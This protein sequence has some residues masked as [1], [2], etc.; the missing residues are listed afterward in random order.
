M[1]QFSSPFDAVAGSKLTGIESSLVCRFRSSAKME[2]MGKHEL[3]WKIGWREN[4]PFCGDA[5][6]YW[7]DRPNGV[8]FKDL[9]L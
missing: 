9:Q 2:R 5:T 6:P 1:W 4:I 7:G 8:V 3:L